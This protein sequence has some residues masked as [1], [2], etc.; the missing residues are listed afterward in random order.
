MVFMGIPSSWIMVINHFFR[1]RSYGCHQK[2]IGVSAWK[3]RHSFFFN[4]DR[5]D[6]MDII[7][8]MTSHRYKI[9]IIISKIVLINCID[10]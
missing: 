4:P 7:D 2:T 8:I 5:S 1:Q 10:I 6:I 9:D 3:K